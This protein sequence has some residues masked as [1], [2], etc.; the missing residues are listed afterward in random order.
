[1]SPSGW[2]E[3]T[4]FSEIKNK[5]KSTFWICCSSQPI[6]IRNRFWYI[7]D[8]KEKRLC[9]YDD[10]TLNRN[11]GWLDISLYDDVRNIA[12]NGSSLAMIEL[13]AKD[14]TYVLAAY[15]DIEILRWTIALG[16]CIGKQ[17]TFRTPRISVANISGSHDRETS[18]THDISPDGTQHIHGSIDRTEA[19]LETNG[20]PDG[21]LSYCNSISTMEI[22]ILFETPQQMLIDFKG[23]A[24]KDLL[25]N[26]ETY[27]VLVQSIP[28]E[29][30]S[31]LKNSV[32]IT[33]IS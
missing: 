31:S 3:G 28:C 2:L 30:N 23:K 21:E 6:P 33:G 13:V 26:I 9:C 16:R 15:T 32:H 29:V 10:E 24:K 20:L 1:M 19:I 22:E 17:P 8:I 11:L 14:K 27:S 7:L 12:S 5:M 25:G 4:D 18:R